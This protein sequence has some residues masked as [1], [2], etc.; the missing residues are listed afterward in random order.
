MSIRRRIKSLESLIY[1]GDP[2]DG[3]A[4]VLA[5]WVEFDEHGE[6]VGPPPNEVLTPAERRMLDQLAAMD[7]SVPAC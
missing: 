5:E 1:S 2:D 6:H 7:A 3:L 4:S